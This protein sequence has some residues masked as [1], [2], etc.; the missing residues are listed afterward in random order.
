LPSFRQ[1][2]SGEVCPRKE[3]V[4]LENTFTGGGGGGEVKREREGNISAK[5][6]PDPSTATRAYALNRTYHLERIV[7]EKEN[8]QKT[9]KR[10][11]LTVEAHVRKEVYR[12]KK[13]SKK[14]RGSPLRVSLFSR[15]KYW[16]GEKKVNRGFG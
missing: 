5:R 3:K 13:C 14:A 4:E 10:K 2:F 9:V 7:T 8:N 16:G 12:Q 1:I 15:R 11:G 6:L